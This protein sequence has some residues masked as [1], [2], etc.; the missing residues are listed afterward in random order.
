[1]NTREVDMPN[2]T[3]DYFRYLPISKREKQWGLF[4]TGAGCSSYSRGESYPRPGHLKK[5]A[6]NW[7][8]GRRLPVHAI[9]YITRGKGEFESELSGT[10][11]ISAGSAMLLFSNVWHRYRPL[12]DLGWD[13]YWVCFDGDF[14]HR[15]IAN[16]FLKPENPV[17]QTGIDESILQAYLSLLERIRLEPV[18]F[19]QLIAA[20]TMEILAAVLGAVRGRQSG[21]R[22]NELVRQAKSILEEDPNGTLAIDKLV[23]QLEV[24]VTHFYRLFKEHT[25]LTPYQYHLQLR[26]NRAKEMLH[27]SKMTVKEISRGLNF[28][29]EFHFSKIFKKKTDFSPTA[30]RRLASRSEKKK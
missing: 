4:V 20:D 5:Y 11:Q 26:I 9:V 12:R 23:K 7:S 13:E 28:E 17:I 22:T 6:F 10:H 15:L 25:G 16:G 21:G 8:R 1:M 30:W 18:G 2:L 14:I 27:G 29:S 24:S 19:E 3:K